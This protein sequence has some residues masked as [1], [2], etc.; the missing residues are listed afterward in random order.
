VLK[1]KT[2]L[3]ADRELLTEI[4]SKL[5]EIICS[6]PSP[7]QQPQKPKRVQTPA[8]RMNI[9]LKLRKK[10]KIPKLSKY[11]Q[12]MSQTQFQNYFQKI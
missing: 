8:K 7:F 9:S 12:K 6:L 3:I 4:R 2:Y 10:H 11:V 5:D 1:D